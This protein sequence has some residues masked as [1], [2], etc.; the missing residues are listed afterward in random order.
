MRVKP[1]LKTLIRVGSPEDI[2][3]D[4][5]VN[6]L[7][8]EFK[9][10]EDQRAKQDQTLKEIDIGQPTTHTQLILNELVNLI[11][12]MEIESETALNGDKIFWVANVRQRANYILG[13]IGQ[14]EKEY[15]MEVFKENDVN[16]F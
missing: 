11:L 6:G 7:R 8:S 9:E 16:I 4:K 5:V 15:H 13:K 14:L 10:M 3:V 2:D 12:V 1:I